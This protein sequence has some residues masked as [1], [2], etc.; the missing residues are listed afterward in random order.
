MR[1]VKYND[2]QQEY[3][4]FGA[5]DA[6]VIAL[7]GHGQSV[8]D[9]KFFNHEKNTIVALDLIHHGNSYFPEKRISKNPLSQ[10]EFLTLFNAILFQ[11]NIDKFHLM[12]FSQGGRF[13]LK[14]METMPKNI[15]SC[16]LLSP[17]GIQL[18]G[19][20]EKASNKKW[21]RAA[22]RFFEKHPKTFYRLAC[23]SHKIWLYQF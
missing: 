6:Y 17:D 8:E 19:F 10:E 1:K 23:M 22:M 16:S 15:L 3:T 11:L 2:I 12:A 5:G 18:N 20:F 4:T 9:Y 14:I 7:H 21:C 13:A